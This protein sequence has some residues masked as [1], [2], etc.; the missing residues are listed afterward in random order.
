MRVIM[1]RVNEER[2]REGKVRERTT[3]TGTPTN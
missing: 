2:D 3:I 1:L